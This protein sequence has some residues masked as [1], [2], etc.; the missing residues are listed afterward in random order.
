[1]LIQD[2]FDAYA[3]GNRDVTGIRNF[4]ADKYQS[5]G[6]LRNVLF[7]G[8]GT[9]DYKGLFQGRPNLVPIYTS[10]NSLN[11]L[12]TY[13][14]DDYFGMLEV[15]MGAWEESP[16][17]DT[18]MQIGVGR[19]PAITV[20]EAREAVDKIIT[21]ENPES[22]LGNWKTQLAFVADDG[23]NNIHVTDSENHIRYLEE[24]HPEFFIQKIYLDRFEQTQDAGNRQRSP[25]A[26]DA[27]LHLS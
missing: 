9:Y 8:K 21:Y 20:R 18:P 25:Q 11:P 15:G 7:F 17:G 27:F 19:I 26:Q 14:S 10:R 23:D 16:E 5:S 24:N 1:M 4:I 13:S 22:A 12:T 3:Y 2:I 6:N